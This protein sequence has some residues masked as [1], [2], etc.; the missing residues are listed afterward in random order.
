MATGTILDMFMPQTAETV[1]TQRVERIAN[2]PYDVQIRNSG[3][4][5]MDAM[6]SAARDK[7]VEIAA[8]T[9]TGQALGQALVQQQAQQKLQQYGPLILI[10][11]LVVVFFAGRA[12]SRG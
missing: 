1:G 10:G 12:L 4:S 5:V 9:E 7:I 3:M 8:G 11:L 6:L 2:E